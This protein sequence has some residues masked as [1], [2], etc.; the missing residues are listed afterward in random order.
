LSVGIAIAWGA[1]VGV[2]YANPT[3]GVAIV[4]QATMVTTGN[5]LVVTTQNGAGTNHSAINW[6]SF[7]IPAGSAT[8][9]QQPSATS[10]VIN[11][12]VT[13][14]PSVIFG[15]LSSNGNLVLVNQA[16]IAVGAGAIVDTAG[17]TASS[18]RMS[19]AD[20]IAGR[21]RFG[22]GTLSTTGVS[23]QGSVLAR[24]GDVV[25]I[26]SSLDAGVD[27]LI[28][29]PNGSTILVAGQQIE[30]TG[31]GLEGISL[32]VQA[33]ADSAVNLGT[34]KAGAVGIFAGTLK[35]SGLIQATTAT[36]EGGK[37]V[38]KATGD[39]YVEGA[40]KILA[41]GTVGGSVDV[42]GNRV[43]VMDQ[44]L[45]DVSGDRGGGTV[46]V[47]GD[48]QG[49][50]TAVANAQVTYFA[51]DAVIK[52]DAITTGDGGK[53]FI[54]ADDTTR[55]FGRI[56]AKG[57]A[58][59]GNGGFVE[60]SGARSL[61]VAGAR[62][63]TRGLN[64]RVGQWLL[65]PASI[66]LI[67]GAGTDSYGGGTFAGGL[68][69]TGA[70]GATIYGDSIT[71]A[72][73]SSNVILTTD[74]AIG[75]GNITF[76]AGTYDFSSASAANSLTLLARGSVG[77]ATGNISLPTGTL[78]TMKTG[79]DITLVAGWDG[80][81]TSAPVVTTGLAGGSG[82]I[83]MV[84]TASITAPTGTIRLYAGTDGISNN[85]GAGILSASNLKIVSEG[86]VSLAG[87]NSV[88]TIAANITGSGSSFAYESA[89]GFTVGTVDGLSGVTTNNGLIQMRGNSSGLLQITKDVTA[90]TG[91]VL[92]GQ[93]SAGGSTSSITLSSS[94]AISGNNVQLYTSD[95]L[96]TI[97][98][99]G[100]INADASG[101]TLIAPGGIVVGSV[102]TTG[103]GALGLT[104][105]NGSVAQTGGGVLTVAGG[106]TVSAGALID[107]SN[108][109]NDFVGAL[110]FTNTGANNVSVRDVNALDLGTSSTGQN[111][112]IVAA[113]D[114]TQSGTLA[115]AGT[116]SVNAGAHAITLD[117]PSNSFA[118]AVSLANTGA[119]DVTVRT[120]NSLILNTSTVGQKLKARAGGG[121]TQI[122]SITAD[123][124]DLYVSSGATLLGTNSVNSLTAVNEGTNQVSYWNSGALS[125]GAI[126][127]PGDLTITA[128]AGAITR[129]GSF[130]VV[131]DKLT[132]SAVGGIGSTAPM[133]ISAN[134]VSASNTGSGD[135]QLQH[136]GVGGI[137]IANLG[138]GFGIQN[139]AS[140]G[141]VKVTA[142]QALVTVGS[143]VS[144]A[145]GDI[146]FYSDK[147]AVNSTV[148]SGSSSTGSVN[149]LPWNNATAISL[150]VTGDSTNSTLEL[151]QTE[152]SNVTT[153]I[154][155][156]GGLGYSGGIAIN[157][158]I[159][160]FPNVGALSL[161][162]GGS[163]SQAAG[164]TITVSKLNADGTNGVTLNEA[165][166]VG[167]LA[168]RS[169]SGNFSF[170]NNGALAIGTVGINSGIVLS[171][172][173]NLSL[174]ATS[175]GGS[176]DV[177]QLMNTT[178]AVTLSTTNTLQESGS[179]AINAGTLNINNSV[180]GTTL[181]GINNVG[182]FNVGGTGGAI[183]VKS[184]LSSYALT[185]ANVSDFTLTGT[186]SVT[187]G[188][189]GTAANVSLTSGAG[190]VATNLTATGTLGLYS[191][192]SQISASGT[193]VVVGTTTINAG[194]GNVG[195]TNASNNFSLVNVT[196]GAVAVT[197][198]NNMTVTSA[199]GTS[200]AL[201]AGGTGNT[202]T[203]SGNVTATTGAISLTGDTVTLTGAGVS[204]ANSTVGITSGTGAIYLNAG[205]YLSGTAITL[206]SSATYLNAS[207]LKP[208]GVGGIGSLSVSGNLTLT[209]STVA[210][211]VASPTSYD[212]VNVSGILNAFTA[213]ET[214][215][216]ADLS[217]GVTVGPLSGA[218]VTA[219]SMTGSPPVFSG[220]ANWTMATTVSTSTTL[221][222]TAAAAPV[223]VAATTTP[224]TS[225]MPGVTVAEFIE[226][227]QAALQAQQDSADAP[228]K[229][230]DTL[231]V[232]GDICR[233]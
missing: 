232:E 36:L 122:G 221:N 17:F 138:F 223:V 57:G 48:Y 219:G 179:G 132:L 126:T 92:I 166:L 45:L 231:V 188:S 164:A 9:F 226:N 185:V 175:A 47:G 233:P 80:V 35:H 52:A 76:T 160:P 136:T 95:T 183:S 177:Q 149:F 22:D 90:G 6:Q 171:G 104:A 118:G 140:G 3:G 34:L 139:T 53:V 144:A 18:L 209:N 133:V 99:N 202:L 61:S 27:A 49:K 170:T 110:A 55:A 157:G 147:L 31:R 212:T 225:V 213:G 62:V 50:N 4:G 190:I 83:S 130:T 15:T 66:S 203:V 205:S 197:D 96:S 109:N 215:S 97:T 67:A 217:G 182:T 198:T 210:M 116:T 167:T 114:V 220:P 134:Q 1:A 168:G 37:V 146:F 117:N 70:A 30:I 32:Q 82:G 79:A 113:G 63:D 192:N 11:R 24:S 193:M 5:Q 163:I 159:G 29:A 204:S 75:G 54:W 21:M 111:L 28:Q 85:L 154:L 194:S 135:I 101:A 199:S 59:S 46:R 191:S 2:A 156:T 129:L 42:L 38:L 131:A 200:I 84:G 106:T 169:N 86:N 74:Y 119:N 165:N 51:S 174:A 16:G 25:L 98:T 69:S 93:A 112:T 44:A 120:S 20:A 196:G 105:T 94:R 143:A 19:D 103:G 26:G 125:L 137:T 187:V 13:N 65:D 222:V 115:V 72:L 8:Y 142:T 107:L 43:A 81:S 60:T 91:N 102:T 73:G 150:G 151:S 195:L 141:G 124:L 227:F 155:K 161:I 78:V 208:G 230:K 176:I 89:A 211:D 68:L 229:A 178:G 186:G 128:N 40:A 100:D 228:D 207:T 7:S 64:G 58:I 121:I 189:W 152:L 10:M 41:T 153:G 77:G 216:V 184:N 214:I 127:T 88:G 172:G 180:G 33:P 224:T 14:T 12:V 71:A 201:I 39:A 158:A 162:N 173:G 108:S 145:G 56:S 206:S 181:M 148:N 87:L 23:V 218:M 123:S